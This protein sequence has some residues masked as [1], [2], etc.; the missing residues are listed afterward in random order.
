MN[1]RIKTATIQN[2]HSLVSWVLTPAVRGNKL[3]LYWGLT[4]LETAWSPKRRYNFTTLQVV[5]TQK[6][7]NRTIVGVKT[8]KRYATPTILWTKKVRN[9]SRCVATWVIPSKREF[10][11]QSLRPIVFF[12][13]SFN[14]TWQG[15]WGGVEEK[16]STPWDSLRLPLLATITIYKD[17]LCSLKWRGQEGKITRRRTK[18]VSERRWCFSLDEM[19][20]TKKM[21]REE[22]SN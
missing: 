3:L 10:C 9:T 19:G 2:V 12:S 1:L 15:L 7:T 16:D 13:F 5:I 6:T 18:W 22:R 20:H 4:K 8:R 17:D 11:T 21:E 14:R